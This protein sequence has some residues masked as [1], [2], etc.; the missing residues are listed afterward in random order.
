VRRERDAPKEGNFL[1]GLLL[2][3]KR[4]ESLLL[5]RGSTPEDPPLGRPSQRDREGRNPDLKRIGEDTSAKGSR[6][7]RERHR[8]E[9]LTASEPRKKGDAESLGKGTSASRDDRTSSGSREG[10]ILLRCEHQKK[11]SAIKNL[12]R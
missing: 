12:L 10:R 1:K 3:K 6:A 8:Q 4:G 2:R 11:G 9:T 7:E 5:M